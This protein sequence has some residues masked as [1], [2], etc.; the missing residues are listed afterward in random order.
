VQSVQFLTGTTVT[1]IVQ[2]LR[3]AAEGDTVYLQLISRDGG[4]RLVLPPAVTNVIAR[5]RDAI[6]TRTRSEAGKRVAAERA[7]AGHVQSFSDAARKK[8]RLTRSVNAAKRAAKK[9]K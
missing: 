4:T 8:A 2:T 1:Y 9:L 7:A 6:T 5:Q 3:Q